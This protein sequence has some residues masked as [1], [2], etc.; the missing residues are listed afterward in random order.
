MHDD[1]L[2]VGR[3]LSRREALA[4]LSA[5]GA[6]VL[7][8]FGSSPSGATLGQAGASAAVPGCVVRP[9][10]I[11]GPYFIDQQLNRSD[12]RSEPSTGA[13]MPGALLTLALNV[14]QISSGTCTP[15]QGAMVDLWQCDAAGEYSAFED[16][17]V[18]FDT[19]GK[20]FLRGHQLT[21]DQGASR[22][23]R[24]STRDGTR[25][26]PSTCTS[27]FARTRAR[28]RRTSSPRSSS[29]TRR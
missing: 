14:S 21:N 29:S 28:A 7:G 2:P 22:D 19:R 26:A 4:L 8:P 11:E 24:R 16:R 6:T 23:S 20:K 13:V 3:I 1:D 27:R 5:A 15:L 17:T 12:V 9:E 18:G 10:L 25:G